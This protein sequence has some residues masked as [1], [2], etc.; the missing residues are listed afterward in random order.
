[1]L[2]EG[3]AKRCP[4]LCGRG[5]HVCSGWLTGWVW[6]AWVAK[7]VSRLDRAVVGVMRGRV[8]WWRVILDCLIVVRQEL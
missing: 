3:V 8:S 6:K 7:G 4:G 5:V 1:M 2:G